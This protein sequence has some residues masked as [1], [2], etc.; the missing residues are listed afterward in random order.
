MRLPFLGFI[1]SNLTYQRGQIEWALWRS[2]RPM[3][4]RDDGP[5][6]VFK[7]RIKRLLD[8][9]R[10]LDVSG[11][12]VKPPTDYAFVPS[13]PGGS[14]FEAGYA[15]SD[16]FALAIALDLLNIGFK[17]GEIVF[18]MRWLREVL[19]DWYPD[20]IARPSLMDRQKRL[21][22]HFPKLPRYEPGNGRVALADARV[23]LILN[24]IEITEV[25]ASAI[26]TSK[27]S[28]AEFLEPEVFEGLMA[29][30]A[31]LHHLMPLHRRSVI[32][33]EMTAVAQ[34]VALFL[35]EAPIVPRGR[36]RHEA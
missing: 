33:I 16:V 32:V 1:L 4:S 5:S 15:A 28:K 19:D 21:A 34:A 10:D 17:Q 31:R 11:L 22:S 20:L 35:S 30:N 13:S 6:P 7:T 14:G 26:P 2:F 23:F 3:G 8:L 36:P 25:M 12:A 24:R 9:D 18:V 27:P 29:L